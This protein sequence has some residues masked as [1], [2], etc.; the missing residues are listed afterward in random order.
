MTITVEPEMGTDN[1]KFK[2]SVEEMYKVLSICL[3][4]IIFVSAKVPKIETLLFPELG[5]EEFLF[6]V[7]KKEEEVLLF[8]LIFVTY[9]NH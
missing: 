6:P 4:K 2:P 1:L 7:S 8:L 3:N 9:G 5:C